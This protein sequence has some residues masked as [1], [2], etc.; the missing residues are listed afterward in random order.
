MLATALFCGTFVGIVLHYVNIMNARRPE[1]NGH[2]LAPRKGKPSATRKKRAN[3]S[4]LTR[5]EREEKSKRI[6][7]R[8]RI[9]EYILLGALAGGLVL[10][11]FVLVVIRPFSPSSCQGVRW[12]EVCMPERYGVHGLDISHY[13]GRI[14]WERLLQTQEGPFPLEFVFMKATEGESLADSLFLCNFEQARHH[15]LIRGAYH[16]FI[17]TKDPVAQANFF[18]SQVELKDGD[19]PPVLDVEVTGNKTKKELQRLVKRWLDRIEEHYGA[20]PILY[21]SYKFRIK[22]LDDTLFDDYPYWIAHYYVDSVRYDGQWHF[23]QHSDRGRVP[24]ITTTVDLDVFNGTTEELRLMTMDFS[25]LRREEV[26][27]LGHEVA[28]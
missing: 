25:R 6:A 4:T 24:G 13:Q 21:A 7:Q 8:R 10:I 17:P 12:Y 11:G 16:Y 18:I 2:Q 14:D 19:L 22:Y 5:L 23:W 27:T 20:K 1:K 26:S 28:P 15:K 3:R 9:A